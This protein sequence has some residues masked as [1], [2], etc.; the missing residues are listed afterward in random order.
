MTVRVMSEQE[1]IQEAAEVLL[2]HMDPEKAARFWTIWQPGG[3]DYL[4]LREQLFA[5]ESVSAICE[6]VQAYQEEKKN[7]G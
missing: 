3:G 5:G 4:T 1:V 2:K 6:K 7:E